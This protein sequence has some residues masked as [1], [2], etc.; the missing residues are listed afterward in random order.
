LSQV[1]FESF[2]SFYKGMILYFIEYKLNFEI[3]Q[4]HWVTEFEKFFEIVSCN[5]RITWA[6]LFYQDFKNPPSGEDGEFMQ[7][8]IPYR[9]QYMLYK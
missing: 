7:N 9:M 6:R 8:Q 5:R 4:K 1:E 3:L 2:E